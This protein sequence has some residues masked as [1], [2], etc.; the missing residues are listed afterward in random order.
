MGT[1]DT[2]AA[3]LGPSCLPL[4]T[5]GCPQTQ[6]SGKADMD[7]K[8]EEVAPRNQGMRN[9]NQE[10]DPQNRALGIGEQKGRDTR[11]ALRG[12]TTGAVVKAG[13]GS[14]GLVFQGSPAATQPLSLS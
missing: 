7:R 12:N 5:S 14:H 2:R 3:T 10:E 13:S 8:R 1:E 9:R 6:A 4:V 11:S